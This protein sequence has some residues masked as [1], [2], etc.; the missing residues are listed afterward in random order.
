MTAP[1]FIRPQT[2]IEND[3]HICH[4]LLLVGIGIQCVAIT[5][6]GAP[7]D[8]TRRITGLVFSDAKELCS[9]ARGAGRDRPGVDAR[10]TWSNRNV[11]DPCHGR[12]NDPS[13]LRLYS[14]S[15]MATR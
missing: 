3:T 2:T 15:E 10:A 8:G 13:P 4:T 6:T 5:R 7:I 11:T 14:D 9:C 12:E 1:E